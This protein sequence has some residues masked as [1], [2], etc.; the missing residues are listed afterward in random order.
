MADFT[1]KH[2]RDIP[3]SGPAVARAAAVNNAVG[4]QP[5]PLSTVTGG[6]VASEI[7]EAFLAGM[8]T[9]TA[10]MKESAK[11]QMLITED[12]KLDKP[13]PGIVKLEPELGYK[14]N[15]SAFLAWLKSVEE[16]WGKVSSTVSQ[17]ITKLRGNLRTDEKA[18]KNML[19]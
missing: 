4:P 17:V 16:A 19:P 2:P 15:V 14:L 9:L 1:W 18:L 5:P 13:V 10:Q 11:S 8:N 6:T 12:E 7:A 3:L